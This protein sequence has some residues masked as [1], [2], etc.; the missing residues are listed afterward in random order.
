[1]KKKRSKR[2]LLI[3]ER[4]C[5]EEGSSFLSK[6][7]FSY[8]DPLAWTGYRRPLVETD[9][10]DLKPEDSS[11]EIVPLFDK[12]WQKTVHKVHG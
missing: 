1:M 9:L 4:P 2:I 12:Y 8:F 11:G 6:L 5:P 7:L 3:Q 10:W